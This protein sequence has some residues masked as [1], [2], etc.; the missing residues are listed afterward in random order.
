MVQYGMSQRDAAAAAA[1]A[2]AAVVGVR[3]SGKHNLCHL[4]SHVF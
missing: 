2:A 1:A 3:R 4:L